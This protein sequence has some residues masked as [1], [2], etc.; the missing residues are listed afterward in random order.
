MIPC[1]NDG[2]LL[3]HCL[4]SLQNQI[5]PAEEVIVVD[6][7][8]VDDSADIAER[9]GA[10]VV[11]E[12]RRG[13]TWAMQTGFRAATGDVLFRID[14][15]VVVPEDT[16]IRLHQIWDRADEYTGNSV[17]GLSGGAE[18]VTPGSYGRIMSSLYM[19]AYWTTTRWALGHYPLSG[20]NCCIR[21]SWWKEIDESVDF[22]DTLVHEDLHLSFAVRPEET[23]WLQKDLVLPTDPR[24]LKGTRQ[25]LC[26]FYRGFHTIWVNWKEQLPQERLSARG[27]LPDFIDTLVQR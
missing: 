14:A 1:L 22:S 26:R 9:Y 24:H 5:V 23:I 13:I 2:D 8:S 3:A 19:G 10:R 18:F 25:M 6:N 27:K 4:T 20:T 12:P 11:S 16:I 21:S 7:G 17:V 15:D